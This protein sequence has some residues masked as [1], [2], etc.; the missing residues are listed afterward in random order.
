MKNLPKI[1]IAISV[2]VC[3]AYAIPSIASEFAGAYFGADLGIGRD[4]LSGPVSAPD[5]DAFAGGVVA[6]YNWDV[7]NSGLLLGLDAFYDQ[8]KSKRRTN[9]ANTSINFGDK[10]YGIDGKIGLAMDKWLPYIKLGYG[11]IKGT[12]DASGYSENGPHYGLGAE[13]KIADHWSVGGELTRLEGRHGSNSTKLTNDSL[14]FTLNY[15]F[16]SKKPV[17]AAPIPAAQPTPAPV[18][19]APPPPPKP[20]PRIERVTLSATELFAFDRAE[21]AQSQPKLDEIAQSMVNNKQIERI[22]VTGYTDRLGSHK[23][24]QKLSLRRAEAVKAYLVGRGV[25][26]SRINVVGKGPADPVVQCNEKKRS[27]LIKCLEPNR[28]IEVEQFTYEKRIN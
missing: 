7:S 5:K 6:G 10:T 23:H 12:N 2:L 20:E 19:T 25:E 21:L 8:T 1:A 4:K 28:R 18:V 27:A 11:R 15:Y 9:S 26:A 14:L 24:N 13:Y 16:D 22:T 3:S 17:A